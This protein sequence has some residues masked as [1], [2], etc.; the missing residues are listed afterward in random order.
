[1]NF[2]VILDGVFCT[3]L[4]LKDQTDFED[5]SGMISAWGFGEALPVSLDNTN[6]DQWVIYDSR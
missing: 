5:E 3:I 4:M 1:M 6:L 2:Y